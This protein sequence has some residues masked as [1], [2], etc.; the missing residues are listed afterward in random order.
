MSTCPLMAWEVVRLALLMERQEALAVFAALSQEH[1]LDVF[2][3]LMRQAPYGLPA[4]QI[5][6]CLGIHA[7]TLSSHLAQLEG[8]GLIRSWRDQRRIFYAA[9]TE[10]QAAQHEHTLAL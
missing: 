2:R 5:A 6:D 7:S 4:G 1:R 3:L 8:A 9:D 10:P